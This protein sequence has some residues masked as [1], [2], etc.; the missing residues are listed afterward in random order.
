MAAYPWFT[1][2]FVNQTIDS[3]LD[4]LESA[5]EYW[6]KE[7]E[8]LDREHQDL[9]AKDRKERA[10]NQDRNRLAAISQKLD[11]MRDRRKRLLHIPLP[12]SPRIPA[13]L[14][15]PKQQHHLVTERIRKRNP[16]RQRHS[17]LR[18]G[19]GKHNLLPR[20]QIPSCI[21]QTKSDESKTSQRIPTHLPQLPKCPKRRNSQNRCGMSKMPKTPNRRA[22]K[23]Q[24]NATTRHVRNTQTKN[25]K[26]RRRTHATGL[27]NINS[28]S[29]Q[30]QNPRIR[31][32]YRQ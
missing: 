1:E 7:Y 29:S 32:N 27:S 14:W 5:L 13:K 12:L 22:P 16:K 6:R 9:S 18:T 4:H 23:P 31:R 17:P 2:A 11:N 10:S 25:H 19:S 8:T 30:R 15:L 3:F 20:R 21:R 26:R 28:L 24:R